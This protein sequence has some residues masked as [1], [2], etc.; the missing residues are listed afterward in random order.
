M[1]SS[2]GVGGSEGVQSVTDTSGHKEGG[3]SRPGFEG[4]VDESEETER[5]VNWRR[6]RTCVLTFDKGRVIVAAGNV[7]SLWRRV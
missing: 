7:S 2:R 5:E 1:G 6:N 4:A 3:K